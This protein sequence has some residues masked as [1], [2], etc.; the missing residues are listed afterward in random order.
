MFGDLL[1]VKPNRPGSN[2]ATKATPLSSSACDEAWRKFMAKQF[3][4]NGFVCVV[5]ANRYSS[6]A[7][8]AT[9]DTATA[10]RTAANRPA[11]NSGEAP[12]AATNA[13]PRGGSITVIASG[14]IGAV[15]GN[16]QPA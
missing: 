8:T 2:L 9:A 11:V 1:Q 10:A 6:F 7:H 4:G 3:C 14:N 15:V 12:T 5:S 13:A 16:S